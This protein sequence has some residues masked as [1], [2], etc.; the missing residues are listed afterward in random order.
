[1]ADETL[2]NAMRSGDNVENS[3]IMLGARTNNESILS[4]IDKF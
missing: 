2:A 3:E 4:E 1:M